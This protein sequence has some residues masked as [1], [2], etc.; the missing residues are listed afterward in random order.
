MVR[1]LSQNL[2]QPKVSNKAAQSVPEAMRRAMLF[3][4][5]LLTVMTTSCSHSGQNNGQTN[6]H[7]GET[8]TLVIN[9]CTVT[10]N[11]RNQGLSILATNETKVQK[12]FRCSVLK[13]FS[14]NGHPETMLLLNDCGFMLDV[15][16]SNI[17]GDHEYALKYLNHGKKLVLR[18]S[19]GT[20]ILNSNQTVDVNPVRG[21]VGVK[22][23][24]IWYHD[25]TPRDLL[26]RQYELLAE[27]QPDEENEKSGAKP[28]DT[29]LDEAKQGNPTAQLAVGRRYL[30]GDGVAKDAKTG[31]GWIR[32]A[33]EQ[34]YAR[35][36]VRLGI[37]YSVG[38]SLP[39]DSHAAAKWFRI[40]AE[41]GSR[42]GELNL[43]ICYAAGIGL[44]KDYAKAVLWFRKS[45]GQGN[46]RAQAILAKM[47]ADGAGTPVDLSRAWQWAELAAARGE[48]KGAGLL[49]YLRHRMTKA[50]IKAARESEKAFLL[51]FIA[52]AGKQ[53]K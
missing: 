5:L 3:V 15:G 36:Q 17:V 19:G 49:D 34:G 25:S 12:V 6:I 39:H 31:I 46:P 2:R 13:R 24:S 47:C 23:L 51:K 9:G 28:F 10:L 44:E 22:E 1:Y 43:G 45:A 33:A 18:A 14:N 38:K 8:K 27:M 42:L 30:S 40:A 11:L 35:A 53:A 29:L 50:Q 4:P 41:K 48:I 32:R 52:N 37:E 20:L 7:L 16:G 21:T 26:M